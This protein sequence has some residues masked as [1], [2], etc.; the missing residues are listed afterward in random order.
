MKSIEELVALFAGI[1]TADGHRWSVEALVPNRLYLSRGEGGEFA[2]FLEG[3][4]ETFGIIPPWVGITHSGSVT[5]LPDARTIAA[6]RIASQDSLHGNRVI[7]HIAY[8]L[9][10]RLEDR[11]DLG[12][13]DLLSGVSWILPLLGDRE[14]TLNVERQYGLVGE[15][16]LLLRLLN[17]AARLGIPGREALRR[18]KGAA[19]SKRD[20]AAEHIAVEVKNTSHTTRLHHFG[21]IQQLDP[22]SA[23]EEVFLFSLGM[24]LDPSAPKKLPDYLTEVEAG[25]VTTAGTKDE[26]AVSHFHEELRR[27]GYDQAYE[28]LYRS[29]PGFSPPH[30]PPTFYRE[31]D[32]ERVRIS[33]FKDDKLPS[34]VVNVGY[35]MEVHGA[36][37][38]GDRADEIVKRLL[39]APALVSTEDPPR[40]A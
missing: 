19:A 27:Y 5:V 26:E 40:Q 30:L 35:D 15:C 1:P 13:D 4:T 11:A 37:L 7:A 21:S 23:D 25:L 38:S 20:F 8:E 14:T 2:V 3:S 29:Q 17:V 9:G 39:C 10:R 12:N 34:M 28:S 36:G 24:R 16:V 22:Q 6:L 18:W 33:S 32:L 31:I